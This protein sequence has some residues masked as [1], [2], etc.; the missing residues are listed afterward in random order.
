MSRLENAVDVRA[1]IR[2]GYAFIDQFM[3][4]FEKVPKAVVLAMDPTAVHTYGDQQLTF[5]NAYEDEY[6]LMPFHVYD[7][8]TG[9]FITAVIR[10]G[11]T[12]S[13]K[14][15]L[16]LLKRIVKRLRSR[17]KNTHIIFRADSHHARSEAMDWMDENGI[18]YVIGF[19]INTKL[20]KIFETTRERVLTAH[21]RTLGEIRVYASAMYKASKWQGERRVVCRALCGTGGLNDRYIVT[22]FNSAGAKYLYESVYSDR[23][24][25]E[26]MIKDHKLDLQSD[27]CSCNSAQA[28]QFRLFLHSAAYVVL[29]ALRDRLAGTELARARFSTIRL[30]LLKLASRVRMNPGSGKLVFCENSIERSS[31]DSPS[32]RLPVPLSA[33][34]C[35]LPAALRQS[36]ETHR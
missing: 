36:R 4:S 35:S 20:K 30:R 16:S 29:H 2:M 19:Q 7:G 3:D 9:K 28:N 31:D 1:L 15:I 18:D 12:P 25:A 10:P 5:F 32:I 23:G 11:K 6:C 22:S 14:E 33:D 8:I 21:K 34:A 27:R 17:W 13:G 26:L 24:N